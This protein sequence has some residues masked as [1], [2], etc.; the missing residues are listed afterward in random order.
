MPSFEWRTL[1]EDNN[2]RI[3]VDFHDGGDPD[4][5]TLNFVSDEDNLDTSLTDTVYEKSCLLFGNFRDDYN[6]TISVSGCPGDAIF[7]VSS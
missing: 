7:E 6:A 3:L 4:I 1:D 5:A 2:I